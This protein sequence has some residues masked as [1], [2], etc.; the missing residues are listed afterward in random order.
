MSFQDDW[1]MER[2]RLTPIGK[3]VY[4]LELKDIALANA[5]DRKFNRLA[6]AIKSIKRDADDAA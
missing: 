2:K 4:P 6:E 1:D 5:L 3:P